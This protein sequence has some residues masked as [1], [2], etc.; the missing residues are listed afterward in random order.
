MQD[1]QPISLSKKFLPNVQLAMGP[2]LSQ[3]LFYFLFSQF[4]QIRP[5]GFS[6]TQNAVRVVEVISWILL[7]PVAIAW[8]CAARSVLGKSQPFPLLANP[9]T[10][11]VVGKFGIVITLV[12]F[13]SALGM[14]I[15]LSTNIFSNIFFI[16][17]LILTTGC[18]VVGIMG[19]TRAL[20]H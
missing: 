2:G 19:A 10:I 9:N 12:Y 5:E 20:K 16:L 1:I 7:W 8:G 11:S 13:F 4:W 6:T 15:A 17:F 14:M 18:T 3:V